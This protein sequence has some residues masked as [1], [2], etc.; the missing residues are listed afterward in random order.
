MTDRTERREEIKL[1][2]EY[3][4]LAMSLATVFVVLLAGL[5]WRLA[6]EAAN[7]ANQVATLT[8]FQRMTNEWRDHLKV[9]VEK[10]Y[11]RPYFEENRE[12]SPDDPYKQQVLALADVRL[13][14]MD[15]VLTYASISGHTNGITGWKNAFVTAFKTSPILCARFEDTRTSYAEG[16]LVPL[17]RA[18]CPLKSNR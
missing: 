11:L 7:S 10:P 16:P 18:N 9:F 5:Q 13:D 8:L 17:A 2:L 15:A 3:I 14:V 6:N 4:K 1:V 12:F